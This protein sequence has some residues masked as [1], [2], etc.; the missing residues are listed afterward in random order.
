MVV[1][2]RPLRGTVQISGAK[3]SAIALIPAAILAE[4]PVTLDN[5]P[6]LSD[7]AIYAEILTDLGATID[8]KED[9]MTIDP[10]Q[11]EINSDAEWQSKEAASILLFDG[12]SVG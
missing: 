5:L 8:W 12:S 4:T 1:G 7:V 9:Q 2:G 3:N 6:H 11:H 10:S